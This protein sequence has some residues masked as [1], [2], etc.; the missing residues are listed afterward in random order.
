[1]SKQIFAASSLVLSFAVLVSALSADERGKLIFEDDFERNESQEEKDEIGKGWGSNSKSR[2]AG[3]KQVDLRDGAMY[4]YI[5]KAADHAVSV[6]HPVEF[7]DGSVELRFMLEDKQDS[8]GLNFADLTYKPVH[9]G[10]LFVAKISTN[11]VQ[12]QD[13]KTGNMDLKIREARQANKLTAAQQEM[14]KTKTAKFAN[15]LET[16]KWYSL[17]VSVVGDNLSVAIDGKEVGAFSSEGIAHPTK[18]MLRLAVPKNAVVDDVKIF[19][20][21]G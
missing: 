5:H 18:R 7:Q 15:K 1:M 11:D 10:H 2:A 6:T 21:A 17:V 19:S 14:L 16:G 12:I 8:L 13:L 3:N 9:A 4:I 20:R